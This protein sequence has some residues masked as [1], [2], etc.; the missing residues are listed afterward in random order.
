MKAEEIQNVD[1]QEIDR[2]V[3][4]YWLQ[5]GLGITGVVLVILH[6]LLLF[7]GLDRIMWIGGYTNVV[8]RICIILGHYVIV[9]ILI[10]VIQGA[11]TQISGSLTKSC[12][13]FLYEACLYRVGGGMKKQINLALAQYYEGNFE[14]SWDTISR[15]SPDGLKKKYKY[16]YYMLRSALLFRQGRAGEVRNLEDEFQRTIGGREDTVYMQ[17]LCASNNMRRALENKD[18]PS[19]YGFLQ[20]YTRLYQRDSQP[21]VKVGIACWEG[22]LEYLCGNETGADARLAYVEKY[23]G[24][25]FYVQELK[26]IREEKGK[27]E[28]EDEGRTSGETCQNSS[29]EISED[30]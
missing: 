2:R 11:E 27:E 1:H 8:T 14:Q 13:P 10:F 16:N 12:D 18:Y 7:A 25:L 23:G 9:Q 24:K 21:W 15:V 3:R 4:N 30:V 5:K 29:G 28:T 26:K 6:G 19:A 22:V 17:L 20:D